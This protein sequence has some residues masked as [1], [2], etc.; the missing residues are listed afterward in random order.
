MTARCEPPESE[1]EKDGPHQIEW[2]EGVFVLWWNS[3][4]KNWKHGR[5]RLTPEQLSEL[6][7]TYVAPVLTPDEIAAREAA[8]YKAGQEAM[9]ERAARVAAHAHLVPPDGG[10]PSEDECEVARNAAT[11]I[12]ALEPEPKP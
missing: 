1:R 11:Y 5:Q 6:E 8:A 2:L 7:Y 9:R 4:N 10:S 12:R 3:K